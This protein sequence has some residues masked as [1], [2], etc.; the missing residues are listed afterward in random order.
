MSDV[1][2]WNV[3]GNWSVYYAPWMLRT[4]ADRQNAVIYVTE[5]G[6]FYP[7]WTYTNA[8]AVRPA[9]WVDIDASAGIL[10][11][12]Y[13]APDYSYAYEYEYYPL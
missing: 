8:L 2:V 6:A 7:Y 1:S 11:E 12:V 10:P 13:S 5:R 4:M 9:M 3:P